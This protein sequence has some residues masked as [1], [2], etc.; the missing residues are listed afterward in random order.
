MENNNDMHFNL[1][2]IKFQD[3]VSKITLKDHICRSIRLH[4]PK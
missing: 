1:L 3:E 4:V 2:K